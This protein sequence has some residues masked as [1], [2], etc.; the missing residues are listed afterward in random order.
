MSL[1]LY[2]SE[3]TISILLINMLTVIYILHEM[4]KHVHLSHQVMFYLCDEKLAHCI[5]IC[6]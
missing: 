5:F 4:Q 1:F 3:P 6:I 2:T